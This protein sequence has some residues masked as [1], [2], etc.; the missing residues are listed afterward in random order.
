MTRRKSDNWYA[1]SKSGRSKKRV[2]AESS[3]VPSGA[4]TAIKPW[5][6]GFLAAGAIATV[7][8]ALILTKA[9]PEKPA[10]GAALKQA[11][12]ADFLPPTTNVAA[13]QLLMGADPRM[14]FTPGQNVVV[15][16]PRATTNVGTST[17][18]HTTPADGNA[19]PE[20]LIV[21]DPICETIESQNRPLSMHP[22]STNPRSRLRSN[23]TEGAGGGSSRGPVR[24]RCLPDRGI[25][26]PAKAR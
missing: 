6:L 4:S 5:I 14:E 2:A 1:L 11:A 17:A 8:V 19:V 25:D 3:V 16:G 12:P 15:A 20:G 21:L 13:S 7:A 24:R 18:H 26:F 22:R 23:P 9:R 10:E